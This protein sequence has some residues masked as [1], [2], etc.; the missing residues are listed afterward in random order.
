MTTA[1]V[2]DQQLTIQRRE[3]PWARL[4]RAEVLKL[5][6]RH[7]L[8]AFAALLTVVPMLIGY[9]VTVFLH[10]NDATHHGPGGGIDNLAGSLD[11]L[12]TLGGIAALLIGATLGAGDLGAG[13]FRELVVTGRSRIALYTARIPAGIAVL[14]A[15]LTPAFLITAVGSVVFAGS[16]E[17]PSAEL[18]VRSFGWVALST[19]TSLVVGIGVASLIGSRSTSIGVLLAWQLGL[20]RLLLAFSFLGVTRDALLPAATARL[21]PAAL[22][23]DPPITITLAAS[24]ATITI[25]TLTAL[26]LGGWRTTTRDA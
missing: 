1:G 7:G 4:V 20:A 5:R 24:A 13:V 26:T 11:V 6:R 12:Q 21:A 10:A 19:I 8:M 22:N 3:W 14:M 15:F 2:A 9:G 17:S 25:W 18:L 16:L 23:L